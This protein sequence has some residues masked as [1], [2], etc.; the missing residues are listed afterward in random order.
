MSTDTLAN[1]ATENRTFAP[2]PLFAAQANAQASL[3]D[4]AAADRLGFWAEQADRLTWDRRWDEV[5]DWSNAPFAKWF[6]G[7][8]LN[9]SANCLDRHVAE[10][11]GERT[12]IIFEAED[13]RS[14]AHHLHRAPGP[15]LPGRPRDHLAGCER[16]GSRRDLHVDDARGGR[17]DA[18]MRPHRRGALGRVRRVRRRGAALPD[19]RRAG[20]AGH[21]RRRPVPP[22]L[23]DGAQAGRR[24]GRRALPQRRARAG[25]AAHRPGRRLAGGPRRLVARV[26]AGPPD[27]AHPAV[28]RLRAPAVH[29]LHVRHDR[30]AQGDPAHLRRLPD[31]GRLHVQQRVRPQARDRRVLVHRRHR[32]GHRALV[33][34]LRAAGQRRHPADLRGHAGHP[35]P[36]P[37]LGDHREAQGD[38]PV[39]R[40][41]RD[42]HVHEV[43]RRPSGRVRPVEPAAARLGRRADQPGGVDVV[44][45]GH[46]RRPLPDRRHLVADRDRRA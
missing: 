38:D 7:G 36:R 19:R 31:P 43:G 12:A 26:D 18:R 1:L 32:L 20:E 37:V 16:R 44:P 5:L 13:G 14:G 39:H 17:G 4:R 25:R 22:R 40:A 6:V 23:G 8:Q 28:L 10:G 24:R 15:G 35:A 21:H 11:R 42:P 41:H 34:R 30:E 9:V 2:D 46:R 45:G 3:Y 33:H 29:P 27:R